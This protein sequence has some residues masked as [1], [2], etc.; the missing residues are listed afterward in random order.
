MTKFK[1]CFILGLL[2]LNISFSQVDSVSKLN[3]SYFDW[4]NKDFSS[5]SVLGISTNKLYQQVLSQKKVKK[6]VI[7]AVLD[8][9]VDINHVDLQGKIWVNKGEIPGN[10]VDD[11][12]NGFIDDV[13][14]WNF[15]GNSLGENL[16][17]ENLEVARILKTQDSSSQD[18]KK[19]R[20]IFE[21]EYN[22]KLREKQMILQFDEVFTWA[23]G[24]INDSTGIDARTI[25]DLE[26][27]ESENERVLRAKNFLYSRYSA[28]LDDNLLK[29]IKLQNSDYMDYHLNLEFSPRSIVGDDPLD[30]NDR[31]YGN[32][33]VIGPNSDHATSVAGV[34]AAVRDNG[35]GINGITDNVRIMSVRAVP[36]G[37]ERDKDIALAI[38]YAVDNGADIINM[39]FGK[40]LSPQ[41]EFVDEAVLYAEKNN[42]LLVHS[43]GNE[44]LNL[45]KEDSYPVKKLLNGRKVTNWITVGASAKDADME[46]AGDFSNYGRKN[47][48][49]FAPGI[50]VISLDSS[51]AYSMVDG[52]SI[53]G[54]MVTGAAALLLSYFPEL[55][56]QDLIDILMSTSLTL[57][58]PKKVFLPQKNAQKRKKVK[59][60]RLSR[61]GGIV[62]VYEAFMEA[63]RRETD[64]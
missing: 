43:A 63:E 8:G 11:D 38:I 36:N 44:A 25:E 20:E 2:Y 16:V 60:R 55:T 6:T 53:A 22:D 12:N 57:K 15:L 61:S 1:F 42:V 5:D 35:I 33:D 7:V 29:K 9:G 50:N 62:N 4:Y 54:P 45:D 32:P 3:Q 28:G 21:K 51:N 23:R 46:V 18:Y 47:V 39:S 48:D 10:T 31:N 64:D 14:G 41:K 13:H 52:T 19:A 26:K 49:I 56:P 30:F 37:D 17:N 40:E 27:V 59:F 34:I 24:I 58:T